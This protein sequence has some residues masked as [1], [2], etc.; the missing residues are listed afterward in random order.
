MNVT[1]TIGRIEAQKD[2]Y[3]HM[4][5]GKPFSDAEPDFFDSQ[6]KKALVHHFKRLVVDGTIHGT[7]GGTEHPFRAIIS[8][9]GNIVTF[10]APDKNGP[11]RPYHV[12]YALEKELAKW[13]FRYRGT[14]GR[15]D[16]P[17]RAIEVNPVGDRIVCTTFD[18]FWLA[19]VLH[20]LRDGGPFQA[21]G[22]SNHL[23]K[24]PGL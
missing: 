1:L 11:F 22:D 21:Q 23:R 6:E 9:R 16:S 13:S 4:K 10:T 24:V 3:A 19:D 7:A 18:G 2:E 14:G 15:D 8:L 5:D 20:H 17:L 12:Y